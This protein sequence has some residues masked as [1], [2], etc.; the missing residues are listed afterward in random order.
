MDLAGVRPAQ[1]LYVGDSMVD[2]ET[3]RR[4]GVRVC[5][6]EYG[7]ARYGASLVLDGSELVAAS[8]ADLGPRLEE[9][10]ARTRSATRSA[11]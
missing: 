10:L 11:T 5:V 3:A 4:A 9:F 1:T 6:A 2:V 7:F 8:P